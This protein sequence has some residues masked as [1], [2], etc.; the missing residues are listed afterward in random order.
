MNNTPTI[1]EFDSLDNLVD[2]LRDDFVSVDQDFVLIYA[3]TP[4]E[5]KHA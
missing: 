3:Y 5:A 2:R 4:A 1:H